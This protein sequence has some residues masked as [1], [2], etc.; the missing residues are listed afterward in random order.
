LDR[1]VLSWC[2]DREI[3]QGRVYDLTQIPSRILVSA[4]GIIE[5]LYF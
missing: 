2:P 5:N 1:W 3:E 4:D